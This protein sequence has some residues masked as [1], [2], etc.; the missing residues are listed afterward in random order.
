MEIRGGVGG[1]ESALFAADLFR[2]YEMY[3]ERKGFSVEI[4][5]R[6]ETEL[7]GIREIDFIVGGTNAFFAFPV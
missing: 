7:G 3:A 2:M 5:N 6:S 1:E 4:V